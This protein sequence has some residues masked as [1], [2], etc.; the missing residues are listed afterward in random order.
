M[1]SVVIVAGRFNPI[2]EGHRVLIELA[3]KKADEIGVEL[4]AFIIDG[5]ITGKDKDK[6]PL[7]GEERLKYFK[8]FFPQVP[9]DLSSSAYEVLEILDVQGIRPAYWVAGSDRSSNYKKL[10]AFY[11]LGGEVIVV[12]REAGEADGVSATAA[13]QAAREGNWLGFKDQM[14]QGVNDDI[15]M[16]LM[17]KIR[18]V[19]GYERCIVDNMDGVERPAQATA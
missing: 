11:G 8:E 7:T 15:L 3:K 10:M 5:Q 1:R 14:P 16:D 2:T 17:N 12:D 4:A 19:M 18:E 9:V 13:R 6:N